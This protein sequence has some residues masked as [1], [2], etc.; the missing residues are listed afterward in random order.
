MASSVRRPNKRTNVDHYTSLGI[1][2]PLDDWPKSNDKKAEDE[3]DDDMGNDDIIIDT[4]P[5]NQSTHSPTF[6]KP[7]VQVAEKRKLSSPAG[8]ESPISS[9]VPRL[10][11]TST[12]P[13][14]SSS[15][16]SSSLKSLYAKYAASRHSNRLS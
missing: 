3:D 9:K 2:K 5:A 14:T 16:E 4:P 13:T 11:H 12:S 1:V 6:L 7:T 8:R 10:G 15:G